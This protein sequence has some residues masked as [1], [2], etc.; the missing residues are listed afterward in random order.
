MKNMEKYAPFAL[1]LGLGAMFLNAGIMKLLDPA[2]VQGMLGGFGFPMPAFWT[3]LLIFVEIVGGAMVLLG[4]KMKWATPFLGIV[5]LVASVFVS[6]QGV[7]AVLIHL[8]LLS[9][10]VS[11]WLSGPGMWALKE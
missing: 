3:W 11:L 4:L 9:G 6:S 7:G 1:R 8:A 10:I 2:M 5:M